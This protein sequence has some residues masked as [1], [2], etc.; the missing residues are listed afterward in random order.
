MCQLCSE[1]GAGLGDTNGRVYTLGCSMCCK[2]G[3]F[4]PLGHIPCHC[5]VPGIPLTVIKGQ[6]GCPTCSFRGSVKC[7]Q[8]YGT[9]NQPLRCTKCPCGKK[10]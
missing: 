7:I 4:L 9:G 5:G 6:L 1:C 3:G 10:Y 8:C 2:Y